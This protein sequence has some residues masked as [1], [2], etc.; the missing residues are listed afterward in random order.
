MTKEVIL[1]DDVMADL[2]E[3]GLEVI[4][5]RKRV[6]RGMSFKISHTFY[7]GSKV[8]LR[9]TTDSE[10]RTHFTVLY[11]TRPTISGKMSVVAEM[12][13]PTDLS[14]PMYNDIDHKND[15]KRHRCE[16]FELTDWSFVLRT[17]R[18]M[19]R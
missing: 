2:Q 17:L 15:Y 4:N 12:L 13:W 10:F 14:H 9:L 1:Y 6:R 7:L 3:S 16:K 11:E 8:W 18:R 5:V 19:L